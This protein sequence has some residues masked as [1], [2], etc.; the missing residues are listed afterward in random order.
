MI[1]SYAALRQ[2]ADDGWLQ[3]GE[4]CRVSLS[5]RH[6]AKTTKSVRRVERNIVRLFGREFQR[7]VMLVTE[8]LM[9]ENIHSEI[10]VLQ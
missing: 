6:L 5:C 8:H 10:C 4:L 7:H 3:N 9:Q 1:F 2:V